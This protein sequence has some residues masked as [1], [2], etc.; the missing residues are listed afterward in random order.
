[1]G[2][3]EVNSLRKEILVWESLPETKS[4]AVLTAT[5]GR[6]DFESSFLT[7][8]TKTEQGLEQGLS[9]NLQLT[10]SARLTD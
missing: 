4:L 9:L 3:A 10:N 7:W 8:L 5:K 6:R 1:M 2:W